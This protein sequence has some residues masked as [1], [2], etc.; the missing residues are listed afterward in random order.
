MYVQKAAEQCL[1]S[2][3]KMEELRAFSKKLVPQHFQ[4]TKIF[5]EKQLEAGNLQE[6]KLDL[7]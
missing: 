4:L 6:I 1:L 5:C 3:C 7:E 2:L